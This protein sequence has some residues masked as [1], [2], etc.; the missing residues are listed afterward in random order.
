MAAVSP[1]AKQR[2]SSDVWSVPLSSVI[3]SGPPRR[4]CTARATAVT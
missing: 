3:P 1:T 2:M 4:C